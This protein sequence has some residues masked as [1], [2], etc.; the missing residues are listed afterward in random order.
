MRPVPRSTTTKN[1]RR[2]MDDLLIGAMLVFSVPGVETRIRTFAAPSHGPLDCVPV[3]GSS[4]DNQVPRH[5]QKKEP[6]RRIRGGMG[7]WYGMQNLD[8]PYLKL[9]RA[10]RGCAKYT[11]EC[12]GVLS[13]LRLSEK[14]QHN[15]WNTAEDENILSETKH[16]PRSHARALPRWISRSVGYSKCRLPYRL[17]PEKAC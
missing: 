10:D 9:P 1:T 16:G 2:K 8:K 13:G 4:C 14:A 7:T 15:Q 17:F 12:L 6:R 11:R 3:R 5:P